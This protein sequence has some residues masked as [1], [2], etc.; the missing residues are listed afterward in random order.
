[1]NTGLRNMCFALLTAVGLVG[2]GQSGTEQ[3]GE[4]AMSNANGPVTELIIKDTLVGDGAEAENGQTAV[5]HYTGWLYEPTAPDLRGRKFDSSLDR[6][7]PFPF[8]LGGGRV[9]RGWDQGIVGM[10]VGGKRQLIIPPD[11][12]YG[13]RGA[14]G[15]I[16]PDATLVFDVELLALQ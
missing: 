8:P 14:G 9:I 7:E 4:S 15:V 6:N 1:M 5:M 16:P 12:A 3:Q 2:C 13:S 10:R 11:L